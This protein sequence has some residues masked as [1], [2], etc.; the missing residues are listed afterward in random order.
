MRGLLVTLALL[1]PV[2]AAR[3]DRYGV[4]LD[5]GVLWRPTRDLALDL[6]AVTSLAGSG[7]DWLVRAGV[8]VRSGR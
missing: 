1:L 8:S 5:A 3:G 4:V 7:P 2:A 6:S